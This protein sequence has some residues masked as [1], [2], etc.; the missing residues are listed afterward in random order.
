MRN[1]R[2]LWALLLALALPA[3]ARAAATSPASTPVVTPAGTLTAVEALTST[4]LQEGQSSFSGLGI[5]WPTSRWR[6]A[7]IR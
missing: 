7:S 5:I 6:P 4:V 3:A 2:P 1:V